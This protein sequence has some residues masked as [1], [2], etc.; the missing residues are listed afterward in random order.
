LQTTISIIGDTDITFT[1]HT[2]LNEFLSYNLEMYT[3]NSSV[4]G[5]NM[6]NKLQL[7]KPIANLTLYQ[8]GVYYMTI[9]IFNELPEYIAELVGDKKRFIS[10]LK[11]YLVDKSYYSLEFFNDQILT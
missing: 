7:H 10:T 6:R 3:F 8:K 2:N 1:I 5:I 4:H 11:K 9:K